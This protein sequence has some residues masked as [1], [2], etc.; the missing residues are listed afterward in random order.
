M[1][2]IERQ[3]TE[4]RFR[5]TTKSNPQDRLRPLHRIGEARKQQGISLRTV[6]RHMHQTVAEVRAQED[7]LNDVHLSTLYRWCE[8]LDVPIEELLVEPSDRFSAPILRH[9]QMMR[10][11]KTAQTIRAVARDDAVRQLAQMLIDQLIELMPELKRVSTTLASAE[12][13]PKKRIGRTGEQTFPD[14]MFE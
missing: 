8:V 13:R 3:P 14:T 10:F 7:V 2:S 12:S 9:T 5:K 6:A 1:S 4:A 11:M